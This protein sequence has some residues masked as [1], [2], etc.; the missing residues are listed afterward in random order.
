[1]ND[2]LNIPVNELLCLYGGP[3]DFHLR[4]QWLAPPVRRLKVLNFSGGRQSS[5]LA[6]KVI[7]GEFERPDVIMTANPG[8]EAKASL[9][10]VELIQAEAAKVGIPAYTVPGP[11][12][13]E[14]IVNLKEMTHLVCAECR[15]PRSRFSNKP[16]KCGCDKTILI[17]VTRFDTPAY[18]TQGDNGGREGKLTQRCTKQFKIAPMNRACRRELADRLDIS[19]GMRIP[20]G[21]VEKWIGFSAS[22]VH[23]IKPPIERWSCFR[24]PLIEM[25]M[26]NGDVVKW[27][28]DTGVPMPP[29]SVCNGCF[30]NSPEYFKE[31]HDSRPEDWAQAVAVDDAI[32]NWTQIGVKKPVYVL[33][34]CISLRELAARNFV[35]EKRGEGDSCDSG[36]CFT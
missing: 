21:T 13:Y 3:K 33:R 25:G 15:K 24:Y 23:R 26:T 29:R 28:N 35:D 27:F 7:R 8:M 32:R 6:W 18:Y 2:P 4:G 14:S 11:N 16:C 22:E 20:P 34:S 31:M 36:Y 17:Q 12:L 5:L 10:Y 9:D 19:G 30:A 1:M